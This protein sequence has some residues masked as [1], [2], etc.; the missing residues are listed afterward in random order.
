M[1]TEKGKDEVGRMGWDELKWDGM[2]WGREGAARR[3]CMQHNNDRASNSVVHAA[4]QRAHAPACMCA[5]CAEGLDAYSACTPTAHGTWSNARRRGRVVH[6]CTQGRK[7]RER[8]RQW[9]ERKRGRVHEN[10]RES[11]G[12]EED[13]G[14]RVSTDMPATRCEGH[15]R[16]NA[17][18]VAPCRLDGGNTSTTAAGKSNR[19]LR[20]FTKRAVSTA[21]SPHPPTRCAR[22]SGGWWAF[23]GQIA[24]VHRVASRRV[25]ERSPHPRCEPSQLQ[26]RRRLDS[27]RRRHKLASACSPAPAGARSTTS[28][29]N[30]LARCTHALSPC[31]NFLALRPVGIPGLGGVLA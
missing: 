28:G 7:R 14:D 27:L 11:A 25:D 17:A 9:R 19:T 23:P 30:G 20:Y 18:A 12:G 10:G 1:G 6:R 8:G 2:G 21:P 26:G 3:G 16:A 5:C 13:G 22:E 24:H 15:G 31:V 29:C 4:H